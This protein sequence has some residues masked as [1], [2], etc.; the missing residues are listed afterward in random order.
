MLEAGNKGMLHGAGLP[1]GLLATLGC[2]ISH[3]ATIPGHLVIRETWA[4][5]VANAKDSLVAPYVILAALV[6]RLEI[7]SRYE[8][9]VRGA[10]MGSEMMSTREG[11]CPLVLA[12]LVRNIL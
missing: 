12:T 1:A 6:G 2:F 5:Q 9:T 11:S 4:T 7:A 8:F 3:E 10:A